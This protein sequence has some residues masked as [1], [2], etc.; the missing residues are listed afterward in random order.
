MAGILEEVKVV[1]VKMSLVFRRQTFDA[2]HYSRSSDAG[3]H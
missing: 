3:C 2:D 1:V